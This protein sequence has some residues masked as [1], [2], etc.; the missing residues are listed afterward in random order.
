[1]SQHVLLVLI[2]VARLPKHPTITE[3]K[4]SPMVFT[5]LPYLIGS[6]LELV[7]VNEVPTLHTPA[8]AI[9]TLSLSLSLT[10]FRSMSITAKKTHCTEREHAW[11]GPRGEVLYSIVR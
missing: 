8:H 9:P 2:I 6:W 10:A 11:V 7:M 3:C 5:G 4:F 1:M